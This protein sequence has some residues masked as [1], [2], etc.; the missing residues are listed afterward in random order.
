MII[1][2][3]YFELI[4]CRLWAYFSAVSRVFLFSA[5]LGGYF[6]NGFQSVFSTMLLQP[7]TNSSAFN[8]IFICKKINH[9]KPPKPATHGE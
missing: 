9:K 3:P 7:Q 1:L 2:Q 8:G 5:F 4:Q 6:R